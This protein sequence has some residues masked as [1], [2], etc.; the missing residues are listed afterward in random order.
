MGICLNCGV[1]QNKKNFS[2]SLKCTR[3]FIQKMEKLNGP[4]LD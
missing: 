2:C 3:E 4:L 1:V